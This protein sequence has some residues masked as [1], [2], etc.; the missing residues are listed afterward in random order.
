MGMGCDGLAEETDMA[1]C[2]MSLSNDLLGTLVS[3]LSAVD[4]CRVASVCRRFLTI[5][6]NECAVTIGLAPTPLPRVGV[7]VGELP[8]VLAS[9]QRMHCSCSS[10]STVRCSAHSTVTAA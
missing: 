9:P 2:L 7:G 10:R 8:R 1:P 4:L 6:C 5:C 3:Y